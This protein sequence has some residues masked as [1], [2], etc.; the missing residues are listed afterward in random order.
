MLLVGWLPASEVFLRALEDAVPKTS[1]S[2]LS[3]KDLGGIIVLVE[4]LRAVKSP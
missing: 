4:Q 3:G 1:I 2:E